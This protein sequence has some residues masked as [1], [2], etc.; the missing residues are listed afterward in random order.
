MC[1]SQDSTGNSYPPSAIPPGVYC[2]DASLG[3]DGVP[4]QT[5]VL[6]RFVSEATMKA[7]VLEAG[8]M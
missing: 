2:K 8:E 4:G 5:G 7:P 6:L 3:C 1:Q